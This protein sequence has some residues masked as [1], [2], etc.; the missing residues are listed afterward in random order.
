MVQ[1]LL[2]RN[3]DKKSKAMDED[4]NRFEEEEEKND[5]NNMLKDSLIENLKGQLLHQ[6]RITR[7]LYNSI[8]RYEKEVHTRDKQIEVLQNVVFNMTL[9]RFNI[10]K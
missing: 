1:V 4:G 2:I 7:E 3:K 9:H 6:Q 5:Y 10:T 8:N